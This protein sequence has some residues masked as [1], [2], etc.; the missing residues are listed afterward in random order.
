MVNV[1]E[2]QECEEDKEIKGK[3]D[4]VCETKHERKETNQ[5]VKEI[6]IDSFVS[7]GEITKLLKLNSN[8]WIHMWMM[9]KVMVI[10]PM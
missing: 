1:V 8:M 4:F 2:A 6:K 7:E 9:K 3:V 5:K 10:L